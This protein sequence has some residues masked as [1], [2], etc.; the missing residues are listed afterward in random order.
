MVAGDHQDIGIQIHQ[1]GQGGV[2]LFDD[3]DLAV[4]V[5]V[6]AHAV[7]FLDVDEDEVVVVPD[8]LCC[9]EFIL[10]VAA[11]DFDHVHP[12]QFGNA[13]VHRIAGDA[14]G[15]EVVGILVG[16]QAWIGGEAAQIDA[17]GPGLIGQRLARFLQPLVVELGSA[18][19]GG[20]GR[21]G[22]QRWNARF[23]WVGVGQAGVQ[24]L[25]AH[26]HDDAVFL[27]LMDFCFDAGDL[28]IVENLDDRGCFFVRDAPG[29][30][31]GDVAFGVEA[32]QVAAGG[33][34]TGVDIHADSRGRERPAADIVDQ[35]VIAEQGQVGRAGAG[36]QASADGD[37]L[38]QAA[39][40]GETVQIWGL[41]SLECGRAACFHRQAS[42]PVENQEDDFFIRR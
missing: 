22:G 31:V 27:D 2:Q 3:F 42:Q 13:A 19:G 25:T 18:F 32:A 20:I 24:A 10:G 16:G 28:N 38:A 21:F 34:I 33:D 14:G 23:L 5:A 36:G 37:G 39:L 1:L 41:S 30:P 17:V 26:Y 29:A 6:F 35:R 7:G 40:R 9:R 8:S 15:L 4:E 12:D 11:L